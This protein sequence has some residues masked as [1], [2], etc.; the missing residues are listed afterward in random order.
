MLPDTLNAILIMGGVGLF[1]AAL[2]GVASRFFPADEDPR[3]DALTA[4]LPGANCGA[5]GMPGC[6]EYARALVLR[7]AKVNLC[8][9]GGQE[10]VQAVAAFLGVEAEAMERQVALVLCGG[11]DAAAVRKVR[12][13]GIADCAAAALVGGGDKA[14]RYGCLGLGTCARSC[15]V[16][17]IEITPAR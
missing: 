11:D 6:C 3:I 5:C 16:S 17:A 12:Y 14:C 7:G 9:P 10:V 1:C 8:R 4:M 13:N 15:P 2:L